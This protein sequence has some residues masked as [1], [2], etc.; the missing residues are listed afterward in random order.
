M[1]IEFAADCHPNGCAPVCRHNAKFLS[2]MAVCKMWL[3]PGQ[4]ALYK[5]VSLDSVGAA[6]AFVRA[7]SNP[8]KHLGRLVRSLRTGNLLD[9]A[10]SMLISCIFNPKCTPKLV[11]LR[12]KCQ[13]D[14]GHAEAPILESHQASPAFPAG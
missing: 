7:I 6:F 2:Y 5:E 14:S 1:I 3:R 9:D 10:T 4:S 12:G 13:S 11:S 8:E